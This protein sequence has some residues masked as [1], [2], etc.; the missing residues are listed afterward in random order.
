MKK[1]K[2]YCKTMAFLLAFIMLVSVLQVSIFANVPSE[3]NQFNDIPENHWAKAS[4]IKL[5]EKKI[6]NG[7]EDKTFKPDKKITRGEFISIINKSFEF[8]KKADVKF[9]DVSSELWCYE[10]ISIAVGESYTSGYPD[11]TFRPNSEVTRAEAATFLTRIF[12]KEKNIEKEQK[13]DFKDEIPSWARDS[14][15]L[16]IV[17]GYMKGYP[18]GTF[19]AD[20]SI[21]RAEICGLIDSAEE[22]IKEYKR[23][24]EKKKEQNTKTNEAKERKSSSTNSN[25]YNNSYSGNSSYG[26][27]IT[28]KPIVPD[29]PNVPNEPEIPEK[30]NIS[31]NKSNPLKMNSVGKN[32]YLFEVDKESNKEEIKNILS[33]K[34]LSSNN[35]CLGKVFKDTTKVLL[36]TEDLKINCEK[37]SGKL[38]EVTSS[39]Y[40]DKDGE[41]VAYDDKVASENITLFVGEVKLD[42]PFKT[43]KTVLGLKGNQ[44]NGGLDLQSST[45]I[46]DGLNFF[47]EQTQKE[48]MILDAAI[49][50]SGSTKM[51]ISDLEITNN[52]FN[53]GDNSGSAKNGIKILSSLD[54]GYLKINN[55]VFKG[56]GAD[57]EGKNYNNAAIGINTRTQNGT[58]TEIKEN[59]ILGYGYH[60]IGVAV[61]KH[62]SLNIEGN[63]LEDIGQNGIDINLFGRGKDINVKNNIISKYGSKEIKD[64]S[65]T[66]PVGKVGN[67]F[68]VGLGI[69]Y[70]ENVYG[71]KINE[72][73][74]DDKD[75]FL[76]DLFEI[77][78]I[79]SKEQN[80][81]N[82][83]VLNCTPIYM[84]HK[85]RF[86]KPIDEINKEHSRLQNEELI[87][88]K[89]DDKD[90]II[91][92]ET[93]KN[94]QVKAIKIV[95][96]GSGKVI[97]NP[98]LTI[99]DELTIDLPNANLQ[100]NANVDKEKVHIL[101]IR[102]ND[103][104]NFV[105]H[106]QFTNITLKNAEDLT[107]E[108]LEIKNK[109]GEIVG[110]EK[111]I[112]KNNIKV[113]VGDKETTDFRVDEENDKVILNKTLLNNLL[114][115][116]TIKLEYI[117]EAN[118]VSKVQ[119]SFDI[120]VHN[121]S[122]MKSEFEGTKEATIY[123]SFAPNDGLKIK[124]TEIK[125]A[126]GN[127]VEID[128]TK[129]AEN[130]KVKISYSEAKKEDFEV[131][132]D[133][134]TIKKSFL[135]M[136]ST[137]S[138]GK[139]HD[140]VVSL[141]DLD[142][143][144]L[145]A[146]T[147]L[148]LN[149]VN[150]SSVKVEPISTLTFTQG[151]APTSGM[152]FKIT[153]IRN[154]KGKEL[155]KK[156][157]DLEN[158]LD[159][160][161]FP[162]SWGDDSIENLGNGNFRFNRK[163]LDIDSDKKTITIKKEYLDKLQINDRD[164]E[165]GTKQIIVKYRDPRVGINF[166]SEK[167]IIHIKKALNPL[168]EDTT[169]TSSKYE[170]KE[171]TIK[172]IENSISNRASV[173]EFINN[174]IKGNERQVLRVYS[175]EYIN[176]NSLS[177]G[178]IYKYK[179]NY[180]N[181]A[182][183]DYLVVTAENGKNTKVY[184]IIFEENQ[185][186]SLIIS[187]KD[188]NVVTN[189]GTTFIEISENSTIEQL[190][191]A[192]EIQEGA[193]IKIVN[194]N[195]EEASDI[196][197]EYILIVQKDEQKE[198]RTIKLKCVKKT[199]RALIVA[200]SD[201][202]NEK[203]N[204]IGPKTDKVL[205][206]K[207][208]RNQQIDSNNFEKITVVENAKKQEFLSKISEAFK[209]AKSNDV[210][211][212]YYSG[213]G[214]N[215]NGISYI[216]T[217]DYAENKETQIKLWISVNELREV[218]DKIPGTKVL[219]L[220]SCNSGGFIG[221]KVDAVATPTPQPSLAMNSKEF[222][223]NIQKAFGTSL[224]RE[225][226]VGYL[227]TNEYKVLTASSE[228]EY[229]FEDKKEKVGK[230][231]KVLSRIAGINGDVV[232]D[233]DNN[234]KISLEEAYTYLEDNVVYTS[235]I[236]AF[237]RNDSYTIFEVGSNA[238]PI[239]NNKKVFSVKN[240]ENKDN[241]NII[242]NGDR[243]IIK[244][245]AFK[246]T[247]K[248]TVAEFLLNVKKGHPNQ[249]LK[250]IKI[251]PSRVEK[252]ESE[253]LEKLDYLEVTAEDGTKANYVI[254][255][256]EVKEELSSDISIKSKK[257]DKDIG[258]YTVIPSKKTISSSLKKITENTNVE[259]FISNIEKGHVKQSLNVVDKT[260]SIKSN[261]EKLAIGDKLV[262]IAENGKKAEYTII[263]EAKKTG[264]TFKDNA[265][266]VETGTGPF[267][268]KISSGNKT[269]DSNV[270]VEEFLN[271]IED[272]DRFLS[273]KVNSG[274]TYE[275]KAGKEKLE[276]GDFVLLAPNSGGY[277][278]RYTLIVKPA[279]M[280]NPNIEISKVDFG[281]SF[282]V[283]HNKKT[284]SSGKVKL[285]T[286]LTVK[287]F[288]DYVVNSI[289]FSK[290][291][292]RNAKSSDKLKE[293][294]VLRFTAKNDPKKLTKVYTLIFEQNEAKEIHPDFG[295]DFTVDSSIK[296]SLKIKS[297]KTNIT[298]A[299]TVKEFLSKLNNRDKFIN[300]KFK[301][302]W[303]DLTE[304]SKLKDGDKMQV[305]IKKPSSTLSPVSETKTYTI[306]TYK[307]L[308]VEAPDFGG[309]YKFGT[310]N[311]NEISGDRE[312]LTTDIT[313]KKFISKIK[314]AE[315]YDSIKIQKAYEETMKKDTDK[316]ESDDK[317]ILKKGNKEIVYRIINVSDNN[318]GISIPTFSYD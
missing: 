242:I 227:T 291:E 50:Q 304:E 118:N 156:D 72:K 245:G 158:C 302:S 313:V 123:E 14:I 99:S 236:Q 15:N 145:D 262:V 253:M 115:F 284:I 86:K 95:G 122:S 256:E 80:D 259:E 271:L 208:F 286:E 231:T 107:V 101:N 11:G 282:I 196:K 39:I 92:N 40:M 289:D 48:S 32:L 246:I 200:N 64:T 133:T 62:A 235:H 75:K 113:F 20:K 303:D 274:V 309:A 218:L 52:T 160:E 129:L 137:P 179:K 166:R 169:I 89:D 270:T 24:V 153:S 317:L 237:P 1:N 207:V 94:K 30:P 182:N 264:L 116:S 81:K 278:Q 139:S 87:I 4:I 6:V 59:K 287:E 183:N 2:F 216:C 110:K 215:I 142:N 255:V 159:I 273:I 267:G 65:F 31:D 219:I 220:D 198:E 228:D 51:P 210:S 131:N 85:Y 283:D 226:S 41:F 98:S 90:L 121:N 290:L 103:Y 57:I 298:E 154:A 3:L 56:L 46:I 163:Y 318:G 260:G 105:I 265:F 193:I 201:Y 93:I 312:E 83:G 188:K 185:D 150:N 70:V 100:N 221:K 120:T 29:K 146:K 127:N 180:E 125:D 254:T 161:P 233:I 149:I 206:E 184:K 171:D 47:L 300:I 295:D 204:L 272:K 134:I 165:F 276:Q 229:S 261:N 217:T 130:L 79:A 277:P 88:V 74:Y 136:I 119:K 132:G 144:I 205:M 252:K 195:G 192:L 23:L 102:D 60:G 186:K 106:A 197:D 82:K 170:I 225:H 209:G 310:I 126:S 151:K 311:K 104:S 178:N 8:S 33:E 187:A 172:S 45:K 223:K 189:L 66:D 315:N 68:E 21:T 305:T 71:V 175:K 190:K 211:Y 17:K 244:S 96:N 38:P 5:A 176:N 224:L 97:L 212:L 9:S 279:I 308:E 108:I 238:K 307:D 240:S 194:Q 191:N 124:I 250:V 42:K 316:I 35:Y 281:D 53:F 91:P 77:N 43:S 141:T 177:S 214:N 301:R 54:S 78:T 239:S 199:Y 173:S 114:K 109:S 36:Y 143:N 213:H 234:G 34:Y 288:L 157:I 13:L 297:Q 55:N 294:N 138:F 140:I 203:L 155:E 67:R 10:G 18:D 248:V 27:S 37:F 275:P 268:N 257:N 263:I 44:L 243:G 167:F 296:S 266:K 258:F 73:Y 174:I 241:L 280:P 222:N 19:K 25:S 162:T 285:T 299:M 12:S 112:L 306:E 147:T 58:L 128:R 135:D 232:G 117:D 26:P 152:T 84:G 63:I 7:Y 148:K 292:I 22:G 202:G 164:T 230:F 69:A 16:M 61:S 293:G 314:N 269:L 168:S 49:S 251:M 249:E 28:D 76:K 181:I 111:S 247:N